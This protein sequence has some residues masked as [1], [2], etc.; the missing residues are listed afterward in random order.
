MNGAFSTSACR[1]DWVIAERRLFALLVLMKLG[2][3]LSAIVPL[4]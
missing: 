1:S 3:S 4:V 2:I